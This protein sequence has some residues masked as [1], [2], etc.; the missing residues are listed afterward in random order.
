MV[1]EKEREDHF[2]TK[3]ERVDR[4]QDEAHAAEIMVDKVIAGIQQEQAAEAGGY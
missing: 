2:E 4:L 1:A 3:E